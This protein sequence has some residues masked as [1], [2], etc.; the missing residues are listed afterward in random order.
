VVAGDRTYLV[1]EDRTLTYQALVVGQAVDELTGRPPAGPV[2]VRVTLRLAGSAVPLG[3]GRL[4]PVAGDG[5]GFALAGV[6]GDVFLAGNAYEVDLSVTAEGYLTSS[7]V[8]AVPAGT[9]QFP[10]PGVRVELRRPAV[11]L[12]GRVMKRRSTTPK[13]VAATVQVIAPAGLV[14]LGR[15]LAFTHRA[16][17]P[18]A[19]VVPVAIQPL[20]A[21]LRLL[22]DAVAGATRLRLGDRTGLGVAGTVVQLGL[23]PEAEYA[24]VD[25]LEPP[26]GP[27]RSGPVRLRAP[28]ARRHRPGTP[29]PV[30]RATVTTLGAG[31]ALARDAFA[32]DEVAFL[33]SATAFAAPATVQVG[34]GA[35]AEYLPLVPTRATTSAGSY[36]LGPVGRA[37]SLTVS[38]AGPDP[39]N[40]MVQLSGTAEHVVDYARPDGR[41]DLRI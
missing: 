38:A 8:V 3:D 31:T 14:G 30:R 6:A 1:V 28:L 16:A 39:D 20:G 7:A 4:A 12:A 13:P 24:V 37:T 9:T 32:G 25:A 11:R 26:A 19:P 23:G 40:P 33:Q 36:R 15:P 2:R 41:L 21:D 18:A 35:E 22:E 17:T 34:T 10:R 27:G 5:G 29:T